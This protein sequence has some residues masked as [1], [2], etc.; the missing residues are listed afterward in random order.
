MNEDCES[1]A[2]WRDH[3]YWEHMGDEKKQFSAVA[4]GDFKNCIRI[5]RE[6][7]THLRS[8]ISDTIKLDV[9]NGRA[10]DVVVSW[11]FGEL[12]LRSGW[13]AFVTA[14]HIEEN[15]TFLFIY[16]GNSNFEIHIF[17]SHGCEKMASCFQPPSE[18][19]GAFPP[20][21][22]A[23]NAGHVQT[24]LEFDYTMSIGCNLT[25]S[26]DEKVLE[27]ARKIRSEIPLYVAI[28]KK[29][30]VNVKDCSINIPLR[31]VSH[32]KEE[33]CSAVIK[34]E[35]P[36]GNIYN[37]RASKHSED[38]VVLQS[39]WDAFVAANHIQKNDLLI[40]HSK[41]KIRLKILALDP[42]GHEKNPSCFDM[43]IFSK[44]GE[45]SVRIPDARPRTVEVIDLTSSDDD[46]TEREDA[47]RSTGRRKKVPG[48]HAKAR[49]MAPASSPSTKSG[50]DTHKLK[51]PIS[52]NDNLQGPSRPPYI[53]A[54][55]ITLTGR[56]EKKVQEKVQAIGSEV[57]SMWQ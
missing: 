5:P 53:L 11:E 19:F 41:G 22:A 38:Q 10:Y 3:Y 36:D 18:I 34:L 55:G 44:T 14:H 33:T 7:S 20:E 48:S 45:G 15:D 25:K 2:F 23:P 8:R 40:F 6:L 52:N 51:L 24:Q 9:P 35:A 13:D 46:H 30:N 43:K 42:S 16:H 57:L 49:K 54:R 37:V 27:I 12:V 4:K 47:G 39:G 28:M 17:N 26:Q 21:Q 31:L 56:V 32:F 50:S 1:C 29:I